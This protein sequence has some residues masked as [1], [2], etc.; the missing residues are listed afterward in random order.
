MP[1]Q[2]P[3]KMETTTL[4]FEKFWSWV[5]AHRNC[6]LSAGTTQSVLYDAE[7]FHWHFGNENGTLLVQVLRGKEMVGEILIEPQLI[8][9]VQ[10][11]RHG[12]EEYEFDCVSELESEPVVVC[13]FTLSHDY[14]VQES[15]PKKGR[16][17]H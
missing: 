15:Q 10:T 12:E 11:L 14:D 4:P 3:L 17:V 7:D 8:S 9:Y 16:L 13:Y 6:I 5:Q 1:T 2:P